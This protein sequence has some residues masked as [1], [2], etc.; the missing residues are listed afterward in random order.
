MDPKIG[1]M[2]VVGCECRMKLK[3][4]AKCPGATVLFWEVLYK[5]L[6]LRV[7]SKALELCVLEK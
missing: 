4:V 2:L 6:G 5:G 1:L 7:S 3:S